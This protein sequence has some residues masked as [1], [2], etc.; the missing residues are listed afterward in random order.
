MHTRTRGFSSPFLA[1]LL[2]GPV[3]AGPSAQ[4]RRGLILGY[5]WGLAGLRRYCHGTPLEQLPPWLVDVAPLI[6]R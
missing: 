5:P 6:E 3:T 1:S 2:S 4:T